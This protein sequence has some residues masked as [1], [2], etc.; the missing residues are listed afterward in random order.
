[1]KNKLVSVIVIIYNIEKYLDDCIG[2]I[3]NQSYENLE[4]ILVDDGSTDTS[5]TICEKWKQ[6]DNRI[7]L[8]RQKNQGVS[9]ARNQ[10][11]KKA[12]GKYTL[13]VDGDDVLDLNMITRLIDYIEKEKCD[14]IFCKHQVISEKD[15]FLKE[16]YTEEKIDI[17]FPEQAHLKLL[18]HIEYEAVWNG[19]Y[20]TELI[21]NIF[22]PV[23][24]KNEDVFW[25]YQ[26]IDQCNKIG[27]I[28]D[29][30]YGYRIRD[31]SLMHQRFSLK[32][33]DALEGVAERANYLGTKYSE[34]KCPAYTEVTAYCMMDYISVKKDLVGQEKKEALDKIKYYKNKFRINCYEVLKSKNI[35]KTRKYS[36]ILSNISFILASYL[37]DK[38][39]KR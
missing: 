26:A 1:M 11:I 3:V 35:S 27:F 38:I 32:D 29:K 28:E 14:L 36:I 2:S 16:N 10:G 8:H 39:M 24:K 17:V 30:L 33:L 5:R 6:I 7:I 22:F 31:G 21:K 25:K 20:K 15:H 37:K 23:R 12:S 9:E 19:I 13:F 4:I 34:L 18:N